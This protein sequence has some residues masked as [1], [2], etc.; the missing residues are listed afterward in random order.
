MA[1]PAVP[2]ILITGTPGT[3][4]TTTAAEVARLTGWKHIIIGDL[5][6]E[7]E[8]NSGWD[9]DFDCWIVDEDKVH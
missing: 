9:E 7:K 6:K 5:V 2:N 4:K 3:G 8:L 1:T